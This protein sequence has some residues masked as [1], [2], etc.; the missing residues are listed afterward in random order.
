[1]TTGWIDNTFDTSATYVIVPVWT[2]EKTY[3]L[4]LSGDVSTYD[5]QDS[6]ANAV[7]TDLDTVLNSDVSVGSKTY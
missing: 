4:V 1:M 2:A 6:D 7:A 3:S 5:V